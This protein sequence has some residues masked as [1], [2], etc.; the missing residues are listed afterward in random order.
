MEVRNPFFIKDGTKI[1]CK[2]EKHVLFVLHGVLSAASSSNS[3][4]RSIGPLSRSDSMRNRVSGPIQEPNEAQGDPLQD[5]PELLRDV[6]E[7]Q[8]DDSADAVGSNEHGFS[9]PH[10][11]VPV[12]YLWFEDAQCIC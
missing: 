1:L 8:V 5:L 3:T 7:N 11:P 6:A 4:S 2:T 9:E 10:R 12:L